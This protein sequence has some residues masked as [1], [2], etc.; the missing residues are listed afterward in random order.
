ML[1]IVEGADG[2]GKTTFVKHLQQLTDAA[3][4]HRGVPTHDN[5]WDEY[6]LDLLQYEPQT[7]PARGVNNIICDR[8]HWG[9][10][11]YGPLYRGESKLTGDGLYFSLEDWLNRRGVVVALLDHDEDVILRR[12]ATRG[13]DYLQPEHLAHVLEK[14]EGI[15][16]ASRL[17][18]L[19]YQDPTWSDAKNTIAVASVFERVAAR[20]FKP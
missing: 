13:E 9:E 2:V 7:S 19:K 8:W 5:I 20:R 16:N 6:T 1:I 11:I 4:L 15:A 18:V 3:V 17:P 12:W 14:Y 10:L